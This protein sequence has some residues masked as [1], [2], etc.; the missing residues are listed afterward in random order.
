MKFKFFKKVLSGLQGVIFV[1]CICVL[2]LNLKKIY[3]CFWEQKTNQ[4]KQK[5][6]LL[7]EAKK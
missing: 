1:S 3:I 4:N 6:S 5:N 7:F 2:Q